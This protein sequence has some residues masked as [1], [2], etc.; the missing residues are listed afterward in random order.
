MMACACRTERMSFWVKALHNIGRTFNLY[1]TEEV[2]APMWSQ[3]RHF[4]T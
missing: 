4:Y 1:N 2:V 3:H